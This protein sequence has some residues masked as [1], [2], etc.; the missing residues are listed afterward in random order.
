MTMSKEVY[1][2]LREDWKK[3]LQIVIGCLDQSE[4]ISHADC[5][6]DLEHL[7]EEISEKTSSLEQ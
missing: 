6:A 2:K 3:R 7:A 1:Q 5:A 4:M